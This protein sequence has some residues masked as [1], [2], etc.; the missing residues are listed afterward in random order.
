MLTSTQPALTEIADLVEATPA[1]AAHVFAATMTAA[2]W[3]S[4]RPFVLGEQRRALHVEYGEVLFEPLAL[5]QMR[6]FYRPGHTQLATGEN[7]R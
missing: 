2:D 4:G 5:K 3:S 7:A 1:R 6:T